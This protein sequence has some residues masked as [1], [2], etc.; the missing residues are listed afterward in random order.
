MGTENEET[1]LCMT[2]NS[3][4]DHDEPILCNECINRLESDKI[5]A[6]FSSLEEIGEYEQK[7]NN[8][9]DLYKIAARVKILA[10]SHFNANLTP[11]GVCLCNTYVHV[12]KEFYDFADTIA[13]PTIKKNLQK[14]IKSKEDMPANFISLMGNPTNFDKVPNGS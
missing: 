9:T 2:C 4:C 7:L 8:S 14:L 13:D 12:L 3:P 5:P 11:I 10:V 1:Y 6:T